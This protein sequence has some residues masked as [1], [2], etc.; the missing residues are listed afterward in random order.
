MTY[1]ARSITNK[2]SSACKI[3]MDLVEGNEKMREVKKA[4][5]E[6]FLEGFEKDS[7]KEGSV[8]PK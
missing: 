2:A 5:S 1:K 6:D 7:D 3:N 4:G 8:E